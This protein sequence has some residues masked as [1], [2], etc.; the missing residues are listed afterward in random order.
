LRN[1]KNINEHYARF[2]SGPEG[3]FHFNEDYYNRLLK[4]KTGMTYSEY[5]TE[6]QTGAF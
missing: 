5:V 6:Y 3:G 2:N 1:Y 4:E